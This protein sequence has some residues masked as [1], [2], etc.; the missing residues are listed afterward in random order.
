MN[1]TTQAGMDDWEKLYNKAKQDFPNVRAE[2]MRNKT[3]SCIGDRP[4]K[5]VV[6]AIALT[7]FGKNYTELLVEGMMMRHP[8]LGNGAG[9]DAKTA[10]AMAYGS[11][12]R[13]HK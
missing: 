5:H 7:E 10:F 6:N 2:A 12:W 11:A 3:C 9:N 1:P 8:K 4:C 13:A